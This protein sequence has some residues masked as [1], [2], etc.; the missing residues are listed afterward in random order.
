M[1]TPARCSARAAPNTPVAPKSTRPHGNPPPDGPSRPRAASATSTRSPSV[2]NS[3]AWCA[4]TRPVGWYGPHCCGT[5]CGRPT[6]RTRLIDEL[7]GAHAWAQAVGLVPLAAITVSKL[8]WLADNEPQHA[9]RTAA[10]CLPHDW[11]TWRLRG[12]IRTSRR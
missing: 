8:R 3:T 12:D 1:P 9:D 2:R 6:R 11:L 7:G 5:T 10:V 4:S